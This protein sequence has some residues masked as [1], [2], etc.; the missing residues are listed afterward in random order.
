MENNLSSLALG[1]SAGYLLNPDETY[2]LVG[3]GSLGEEP[4][5]QTRWISPG[6]EHVIFTSGKSQEQS[7]WCAELTTC[8]VQKLEPDAAPTGTGVVYDRSADGPT[9]VVSLLPGDVPVA[10]GENAFYKGTSPDANSIAFAIN[11]VLYVRVNNG[12]AGAEETQQVSAGNPTFAGLSDDGRFLF[13]VAGG[14]IHRFDTSTETDTPLTGIGDAKVVAVSGDGSHAYFISQEEIGG[15]GT[16]GQPNMYVWR[17]GTTNYIATVLPSETESVP[18][19]AVWTTNVVGLQLG[20]FGLGASTARTTPDGQVLAFESRAQLTSYD[21]GGH[22]E[23]YRYKDGAGIIC[24]SC[25]SGHEASGDAHFQ[26]P[27]ATDYGTVIHNVSDDGTRVFFE[28]TEA[29]V[30]RDSTSANDVYEWQEEIG[31]AG[32][33]SL[34]SSGRSVDYPAENS[35]L[36]PLTPKP[37]TLLSVT[38]DGHDVAFLSQDVLA[39]GAGEGGTSGIYDARVDGG[40]PAP[41]EEGTC[42]EEG[43]KSAGAGT[44]GPLPSGAPSEATN[45]GGNVKKHRPRHRC[46]SG[47]KH[48]RHRRCGRNRLK[49]HPRQASAAALAQPV[50]Q[51]STIEDSPSASP[52]LPTDSTGQAEGRTM[53]QSSAFIPQ[54]DE[55]GFNSVGADLSPS[56]AGTPSDFKSKFTLNFRVNSKSGGVELDAKTEELSIKLPPG[57]I[58][59]PRAVPTCSMGSF[60]SGYNCSPD[61]QVGVA[62]V[63]TLLLGG[64][65]YVAP[66]Y[67]IEPPHPDREVAR[68]GFYASTFLVFIDVS[69][70]TAS[71]YGVTATVHSANALDALLRAETTIWGNPAD[72]SHDEQRVTIREAIKCSGSAFPGTACEQPGRKRPSGVKDPK[73][74]FTNPA[75]CQSETVGFEAKSYQLP[76]Q[77]F[78]ASAPLSPITECTGLPFA[79]SFEAEPTSKVAGAPTGLKTKLVLPQH[80]GA[81]E[82]ATATMREAKVT[83]PAGLQVAAGAAN[84]I[85]VCSDEQVGFHQEVDVDCPDASKLGTATITSPALAVP[86][87]GAIYQRSPR[88][89]QQLGLWL[90]ADALG[91]HIKIPGELEPDKATGRVTAVFR[92]LPQ[93]PVGQID[94][95]V[96]GGPRAPLQNPDHCGTYT[97]DYTF[98]PHSNDPPVSGSDEMQI[99][100]GCDQPF[101]PTLKAG[102]TSPVAGKFSPFV[103]D[104]TRPDGQQALR[105]FELHL[106]EGALGKP[107]GVPLCPDANATA[108]TCPAASRIGSLTATSGPGPEPFTIPEPGKPEPAIYFAGPYEGAPFSIVSEVRAQAGPFDLGVLAVRSALQVDPETG[109]ATVKADPLP[110]FFEGVGLTYRHLHA[111]VDRPEFFLNP[112]DCHETAVTSDVTS[113][114]GTVAHPAAR[115]QV[116]GCKALKFKPKLSLELKGGTER[117]DYPAF[118]AVLKARKGDANIAFVQAALPHSEFIAQEHFSTI[119]TRKQFAADKCPKGSIYGRAKAITPLLDKP[120]SGPVYLR[121]SDHPLP[122]LVVKLG[123]QL[124]IHLVGRVDSVRGGIRTSFESVPD[125]PVTKFVLQMRGGKKGLF[126]NS[127]DVCR[128]SHRATVRMKAQNGRAVDLRPKLV[129][130]GCGKKKLGKTKKHD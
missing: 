43:C 95:D 6:G 70:R 66:V 78:T 56:T 96:W 79:P 63:K 21:N 58:G 111:V 121:S 5:V 108:G 49:S 55:Y 81:D 20:E 8:K 115:F 62:S 16:V 36:Q 118:T 14:D 37:N 94:L 107:A 113:T 112:T 99:T 44:V 27:A 3:V 46:R 39:P 120:L 84:W 117:A 126:V 9:R 106:P 61:S 130:A 125:A 1:G 93:V 114:T 60:A 25:N 128:G 57:L 88:P 80:L 67:N 82:R 26:D 68:F 86:I 12:E 2:E 48:K 54:F 11:G 65:N 100:E 91:M 123:G 31:G 89:G 119:C 92:D 50:K 104:L 29:L 64:P 85:G 110:Q 41:E 7:L 73:W 52:S 97:T 74:F 124:E 13:Y 4:F 32:K 105:G 122:D 47:Q 109:R 34:I 129:A 18:G 40:F 116:D 35:V 75:A 87:E 59:N 23:I 30:D 83:L 71:D 45:G 51:G 19:I 15:T 10:S 69:V 90:T 22:N 24:V 76:G 103:F 102:V 72:A 77:I 33:V 101:S 38:P 53:T 98:A 17:D 127:T 28:T 42:A